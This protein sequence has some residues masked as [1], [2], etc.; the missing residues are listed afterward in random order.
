MRVGRE[1]TVTVYLWGNSRETHTWCEE[2]GKRCQKVRG[3]GVH[4]KLYSV[5]NFNGTLTD[6]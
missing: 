1:L 3:C 2:D 5:I 4:T 6:V